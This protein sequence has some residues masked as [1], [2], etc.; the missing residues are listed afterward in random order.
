MR[1]ILRIDDSVFAYGVNVAK[2]VKLDRPGD[3]RLKGTS[4]T[5]EFQQT[6]AN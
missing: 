2:A 1:P 4:A 3:D 5:D 6:S